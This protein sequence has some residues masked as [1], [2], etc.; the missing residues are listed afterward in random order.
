MPENTKFETDSAFFHFACGLPSR[1]LPQKD[2]TL[3]RSEY[4]SRKANA[5]MADTETTF[6]SIPRTTGWEQG[7]KTQPGQYVHSLWKSALLILMLT[8]LFVVYLLIKPGEPRL[9]NL[10]DNISQGL[11][12]AVGLLLTLPLFWQR[13]GRGGRFGTPFTGDVALARTPQ[14]WVPL[15]LGL[16]ILSYIVGQ[17]VWTYNENIAH[18]TVIFPTWADAGFL[19]SYP[20]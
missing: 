19:G 12:E 1:Q 3:E 16:A 18:L 17:A 11:L 10:G 4:L 7:T 13:S 14:R 8:G 2:A 6:Q 9:V 20:F 15:L 5:S